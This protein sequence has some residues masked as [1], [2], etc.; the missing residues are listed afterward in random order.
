VDKNNIPLE[1][2]SIFMHF[3]KN[4]LDGANDGKYYNEYY[5]GTKTKNFTF[6]IFFDRPKFGKKDIEL[7]SNRVKMI[8]STSDKLT[9]YIFYSS[10]LE[11]KQKKILL[12]NDNFM[13]LKNVTKIAEAIVKN[14]RILVTMNSPLVIRNHNRENNKD[15]YYSFLNEFFDNETKGVLKH[16]LECQGFN[17]KYLE[18]IKIIPIKCKKVIVKHYNCYIEASVGNFLIEGNPAVL[19]YLMQAG[20]GSRKSE[21][22]GMMELLT[23]NV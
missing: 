20:V 1:Y 17:D 5:S 14:N 12:K 15:Y 18:E 4:C 13:I 8:F 10:F 2:R 11:K 9:G 19:T 21:G 3:L 23:E 7:S 6:A 22:F 16:Q